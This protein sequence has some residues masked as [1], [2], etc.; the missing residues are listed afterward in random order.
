MLGVI[1][2]VEA[3]TSLRELSVVVAAWGEEKPH[4]Q[5]FEDCGRLAYSWR[6]GAWCAR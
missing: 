2:S 3:F 4:R 6:D 5:N 1:G